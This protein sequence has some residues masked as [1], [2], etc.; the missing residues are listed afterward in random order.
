MGREEGSG[1]GT[2]AYLWQIHFDIWQNQYNIVKLN[3]IKL[4]YIYIIYPISNMRE[5]RL[6]VTEQLVQDHTHFKNGTSMTQ[7]QDCLNSK[8]MSFIENICTNL[9]KL[10]NR[11]ILENL[12]GLTK[13]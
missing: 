3:K 13:F 5:L 4:I 11:Y 2:H 7:I 10:Y 6:K 9:S 1:W 12:S 8:P